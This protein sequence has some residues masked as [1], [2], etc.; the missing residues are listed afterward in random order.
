MQLK[1]VSLMS[2]F[3]PLMKLGKYIPSGNDNEDDS[4]RLKEKDSNVGSRSVLTQQS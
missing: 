3:K 2:R 1:P 4:K